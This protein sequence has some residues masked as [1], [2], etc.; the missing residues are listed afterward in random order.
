EL[1]SCF[2]TL[3]VHAAPT[4]EEFTA[5]ET[6]YAPPQV[7]IVSG[8]A[9]QDGGTWWEASGNEVTG[10]VNEA[11]REDPTLYALNPAD[12]TQLPRSAGWHSV[13]SRWLSTSPTA[14][15]RIVPSRLTEASSVPCGLKATSVIHLP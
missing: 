15:S 4:S 6:V 13:G 10:W 2:G 12:E 11:D 8:P 3:Q 5:I 9:C 7:H 1:A 14:Q